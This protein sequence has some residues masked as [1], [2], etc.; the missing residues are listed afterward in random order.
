[1]REPAR[2]R[3]LRLPTAL[4]IVIFLSATLVQA[5]MGAEGVLKERM[6]IMRTLADEMKAVALMLRGRSPF[7]AGRVAGA[8]KTISRHG[9]QFVSLFPQDSGGGV[10]EASPVIWRDTEG[11]R[12]SA[13][14][15]VVAARRLETAAARGDRSAIGAAFRVLGKS[16]SACHRDYRVKKGPERTRLA[17]LSLPIV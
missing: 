11:F 12:N 3:S 9:G 7:D 10:S 6:E 1:M 14:S 16:C 8:A 5:H 17:A 4:A 15:M 13:D 2:L